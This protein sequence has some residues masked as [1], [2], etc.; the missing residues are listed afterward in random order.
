MLSGSSEVR[1]SKWNRHAKKNTNQ[2]KELNFDPGSTLTM[3]NW[4]Q[5]VFREYE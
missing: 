4:P 5:G 1:F 2:R 3:N